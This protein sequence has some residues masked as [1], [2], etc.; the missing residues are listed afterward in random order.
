MKYMPQNYTIGNLFQ[1]EFNLIIFELT[2]IQFKRH[3]CSLRK[4]LTINLINK[5]NKWS[6]LF[7]KIRGG[8][9]NWYGG[10]RSGSTSK[11]IDHYVGR[12]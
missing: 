5:I 10:S 11:I 2:L 3:A 7:L 9:I 12:P 8:L 1:Y 4:T 6:K